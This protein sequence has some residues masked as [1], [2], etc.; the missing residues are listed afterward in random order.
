M[1]TM[2]SSHQEGRLLLGIQTSNNI[3]NSSHRAI[4]HSYDVP[5]TTLHYRIHGRPTRQNAQISNRKLTL[6][7]EETLVQWILSMDGRG[8]P[9]RIATVRRMANVLLAERVRSSS[10]SPPSVGEK[11]VQR[12]VQRHPDLE[13]KYSRKYDHRRAQCEDPESIRNWFNLV[14]N[15]KAKYGITDEDTYNFDETGFQMGIISTAKVITGSEKK[16]RPVLTQPGNREWVTVIETIN[17]YG[18][19][20]PP[21]II[22]AGKMHQAA[23]YENNTLPY[24]W[25]IGVSENGWTNDNLGLLWL[26]QIFNKYSQPRTIGQYRLLILDGHGSHATPEFDRFCSENSI[27]VLYMP[28]HSSHLLQPLDVGCFSPLKKSYGRKVEEKMRLGINHIDKLEFLA[29]YKQART[30]SIT[31]NNIRSGFAATGLVP[32]DPD[33]V[34]SGLHIQMRTPSPPLLLDTVQVHWTPKTPHNPMELESQARTIKN[35]LKRCTQSPPSPT[36]QALNQLVKGCHMAMHNAALLTHENQ[37]LRASNEKQKQ[38]RT[39]S[40]TYVATEGILTVEEG[41]ACTKR[42][43]EGNEGGSE[44]LEMQPKKRAP[45]KCSLCSSYEHTARTCPQRTAFN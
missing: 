15:T 22:L 6:T 41:Q 27:I 20:L 32:Y 34:L 19:A 7:E 25:T 9:P 38:K 36:D 42:K 18:W 44:A 2:Q 12:F 21:M 30:E 1:L 29:I 4:A 23:W 40:R 5:N 31:E 24:D 39:K 3:P 14:R 16:G 33:R 13:S 26:Q 28:P 37:E 17:S 11:W 10:D 8:L 43:R 45:A 35:I